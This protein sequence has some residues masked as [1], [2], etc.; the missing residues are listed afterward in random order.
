MPPTGSTA[1]V[2]EEGPIAQDIHGLNPL[3]SLAS[4]FPTRIGCSIILFYYTWLSLSLH[5]LISAL[6]LLPFV[7][8]CISV[9]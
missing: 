1:S 4:D 3:S 2:N 9:A 8:F 5:A 7:S 6:P